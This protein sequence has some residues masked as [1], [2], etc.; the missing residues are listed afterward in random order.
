MIAGLELE[1]EHRIRDRYHTG[2]RSLRTVYGLRRA[3]G[4]YRMVLKACK[5]SADR[6]VD[7]TGC[8]LSMGMLCMRAAMASCSA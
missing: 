5:H 3:R 1:L 8:T 2:A 4:L 7:I 6:G